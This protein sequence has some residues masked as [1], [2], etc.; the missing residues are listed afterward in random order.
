M[1]T[2]FSHEATRV[3]NLAFSGIRRIVDEAI[4]LE[5]GGATIIHLE[6]GRPDFDTPVHIKAAASAALE[7]GEVHYTANLGTPALRQAIADKFIRDSDLEYSPVDEIMVTVGASEAVFLALSAFLDE[8]QDILVPEPGWLNYFNVP[9]VM[10]ARAVTYPLREDNGFRIR[11]E[12][13]EAALTRQTRIL[14]VLSPANPTGMVADADTLAGLAHIAQTRDLLVISDEIYEKIIYDDARH[15]SIAS[16]PQ[17]RE[18]TIVI[19]GFSKAYSMTGW[20]LGYAAAPRELMWPM[21]R[22]HQQLVTCAVSFAQAG[23]VAALQG[24]QDCI[25]AMTAEYKR[26]RDLLVAGL[27]AIPGVRCSLPQ[28]AFY[29]FPNVKAFGKSS[30]DL[31]LYLLRTAGVAVVPGT[32]FGTS[33]E[34]YLRLS[35]ANSYANIEEALRRLNVALTELPRGGETHARH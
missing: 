12:D 24:P 34:G 5:E 14:L 6:V 19:N 21:L 3:R 20:R 9:Q 27:N 13:V 15:I 2:H 8:G 30:E 31:A 35:Y 22:L 10:R 1:A 33:G 4:R 7:R 28:G 16:L 17:M 23:G 26:R 29:V 32:T 18:R 25:A 11:P